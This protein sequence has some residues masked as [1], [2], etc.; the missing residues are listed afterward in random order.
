VLP[1]PVGVDLVDE[2]GALLAAVTPGEVALTVA[3]DVE[4]CRTRRGTGRGRA[5]D[6]VLED[7]GEDGLPCHGTSFGSSPPA[8]TLTDTARGEHRAGAAP[9]ELAVSVAGVRGG[10][11]GDPG[12]DRRGGRQPM[13][14]EQDSHLAHP[15]ARR[16]RPFAELGR[17][18]VRRK[19]RFE[20]RDVVSDAVGE[21][22]TAEHVECPDQP[23]R[24][25]VD[26]GERAVAFVVVRV[27][28]PVWR[29]E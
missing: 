5:R 12:G 9:H 14:D 23:G 26:G 8:P 13:E 17:C 20:V 24:A 4:P 2:H 28:R 6:G 29:G 3:V 27:H 18:P 11:L 21:P 25:Q 19:P 10:E 15:Q 22:A 1:V 7:A 16:M